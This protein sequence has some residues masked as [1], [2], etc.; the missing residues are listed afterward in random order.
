MAEWNPLKLHLI[1]VARF[2]VQQQFKQG[3]QCTNTLTTIFSHMTSLLHASTDLQLWGGG[4]V[5][6]SYH[7][8]YLSLRLP[9]EVL[10]PKAAPEHVLAA[11]MLLHSCLSENY[12]ALFI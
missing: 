5:P 6:T 12:K 11:C 10:K 8:T 4:G 3:L 9:E 7:M 1:K 2:Q